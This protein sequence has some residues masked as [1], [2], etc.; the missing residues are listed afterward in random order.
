[1]WGMLSKIV[2]LLKNGFREPSMKTDWHFNPD[3]SNPDYHAINMV[4]IRTCPKNSVEE[5]EWVPLMQLEKDLTN[6]HL[7]RGTPK[8]SANQWG[9]V[10]HYKPP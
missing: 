9:I 5:G 4:S 1:M 6:I 10:R 3:V 2:W 8:A 7:S